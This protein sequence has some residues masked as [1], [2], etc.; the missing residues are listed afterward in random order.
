VKI[1]IGIIGPGESATEDDIKNAYLLGKFIAENGWILLT[2]GRNAGVMHSASKG[3]KK[4]NGLTVGIL[5]GNDYDSL[6]E[7]VDIPVITGLGNARN[8]VNV[9]SSTIIVA[10]GIGP[11]TVSEIALAIKAGKEIILLV[12]NENTSKFFTD[13]GDKKIHIVKNVNEAYALIINLVKTLTNS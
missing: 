5:P 10:C 8:N 7:Y 6:S 2:G 12:N 9:L 4:G 1:I 13:L 3:T 11:G